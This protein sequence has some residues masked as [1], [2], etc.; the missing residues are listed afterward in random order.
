[1]ATR[2]RTFLSRVRNAIRAGVGNAPAVASYN[3]QFPV[4]IPLTQIYNK[5]V[6]TTNKKMTYRLLMES[7]PELAGAI[8]RVSKMIRVSYDGMVVKPGGEGAEEAEVGTREE[9]N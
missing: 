5:L 1:M 4:L 7:D 2:I 8:D 6:A 9:L 3:L